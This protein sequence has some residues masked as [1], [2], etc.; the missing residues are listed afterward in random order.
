MTDLTPKDA[1]CDVYDRSN[2]AETY[3]SYFLTSQIN[4][5]HYEFEAGVISSILNGGKVDSWGDI[6]CGTGKHICEIQ[7]PSHVKR[8]GIDR[9]HRM[10]DVA[11]G[12]KGHEVTFEC[13]D[14]LGADLTDRRFDL[15]THLWYGYVHQVTLNKV[16]EF[17][18]RCAK[19]T[20][21]DGQF[22]LGI[23]DPLDV[24][25]TLKHKN[26][27]VYG[28]PFNI[29]AVTWSYTEPWSGHTYDNCIA[30]HTMKIIE[31]VSPYFEQCE[32]VTYPALTVD[33]HWNRKALLCRGRR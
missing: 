22:F 20:A 29:D 1:I 4:R 25:E 18:E 6:A 5:G 10:L 14:L 19:L 7:G 3:D 13:Q 23:C 33:G 28:G 2:Y 32:V 12:R 16:L 21:P 17:I 15:V 30:P 24:F 8:W 9:S 11:K 31:L 27:L 26:D